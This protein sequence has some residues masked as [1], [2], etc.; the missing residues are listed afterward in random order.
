L[1]VTCCIIAY[2]NLNVGQMAG[3]RRSLTGR[4]ICSVLVLVMLVSP[5]FGFG[6][7]DRFAA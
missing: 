3:V 5:I 2:L 6:Q 4:Y 1:R 7:M